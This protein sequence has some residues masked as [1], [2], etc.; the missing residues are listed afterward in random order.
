MKNRILKLS[1][2]TPEGR[3]IHVLS[4]GE[5]SFS[6]LIKET[7]LSERGLTIKLKELLQLGLVKLNDK[8]YHVDRERLNNILAASY[9]EI[10]WIAA[11]E[12]VENH[13]K[14]LSV[15]LYESTAKG[16]THEESDVDLVTKT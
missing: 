3:I 12:I 15:V 4:S 1:K 2:F 7:G 6:E 11:Y 16:K 9:K 10:T 8:G 14:V 13:P 5:K